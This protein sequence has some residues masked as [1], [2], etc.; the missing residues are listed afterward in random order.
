MLYIIIRYHCTRPII[1]PGSLH[2]IFAHSEMHI[3]QLGPVFL[4]NLNK[5]TK[6]SLISISVLVTW[7]STK[8][9]VNDTSVIESCKIAL[10]Q[11][12]VSYLLEGIERLLTSL[13]SRKSR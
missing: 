5:E 9:I 4:L 3:R 7:T 12:M 2:N 13:S 10:D 1:T 8:H 11:E 6:K